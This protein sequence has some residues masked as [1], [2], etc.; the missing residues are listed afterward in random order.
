VQQEHAGTA[1]GLEDQ[2]QVI[3]SWVRGAAPESPD[4]AGMVGATSIYGERDTM[5]PAVADLQPS[6]CV[7]HH[8]PFTFL[9]KDD[10]V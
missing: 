1:R 9:A 2:R 5:L 3:R 10:H 4:T 8:R 6:S 7:V